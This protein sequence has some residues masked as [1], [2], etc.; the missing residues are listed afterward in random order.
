[1]QVTA[2]VVLTIVAVVC[3]IVA[4]LLA[5]TVI[6]SGN[7]DAWVAGG[8]AAFAAAHLPFR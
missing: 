3:F 2:S 5:L 8:L 4:L 6:D 1:M 7:F